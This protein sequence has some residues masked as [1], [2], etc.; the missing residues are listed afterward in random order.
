VKPSIPVL[1]VDDDASNLL[2]L[3]ALL[4][5]EGFEVVAARS[6]R[7]AR[8]VVEA[9]GVFSAALVDRNLDGDDGLAL[10]AELRAS[11]ASSVVFILSGDP[12]ESDMPEGIDGWLLKGISAYELIR[13][14]RASL[15]AR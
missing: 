2:T 3:T 11:A 7:E 1:L 14:V 10:A 13:Q 5:E 12:P 4:E 8:A 15:Q 6:I 9:S